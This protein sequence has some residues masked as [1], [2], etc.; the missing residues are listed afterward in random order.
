MS[1]K[2]A[3]TLG[4]LLILGVVMVSGCTSDDSSDTYTPN[5]GSSSGGDY[6]V[7]A[8]TT[9]D[10]YGYAYDNQGNV[11]VSDGENTYGMDKDGN[12][13]EYK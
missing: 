8:G 5:T 12:V 4:I 13:Y 6:Q 9:Q 3:I 1:K 10:G 11:A 2:W 7:T